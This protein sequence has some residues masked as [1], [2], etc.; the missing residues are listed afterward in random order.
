MVKFPTFFSSFLEGSLS[1]SL[2]SANKAL[3][4]RPTTSFQNIQSSSITHTPNPPTHPYFSFQKGAQGKTT[5]DKKEKPTQVINLAERKLQLEEENGPFQTRLN[6]QSTDEAIDFEVARTRLLEKR[7]K[8]QE[9]ILS[10]AKQNTKPSPFKDALRQKINAVANY[11]E[12][13]R[14]IKW[15][16]QDK[17]SWEAIHTYFDLQ[18]GMNFPSKYN[19]KFVHMLKSNPDQDDYDCYINPLLNVYFSDNEALSSHAF[20]ILK[21]I[22]PNPESWLIANWAPGKQNKILQLLEETYKGSFFT[23]S[24]EE[25]LIREIFKLQDT[26]KGQKNS[27][28]ILK[29]IFFAL[30]QRNET[31][32]KLINNQSEMLKVN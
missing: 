9:H 26:L 28:Q 19:R 7:K 1:T 3:Q 18:F 15:V 29:N 31:Y 21:R 5:P 4:Q 2:Y 14:F 20:H 10:L 8:E 11:L 30:S 24:N 32:K 16:N 23:N 25:T 22:K 6:I 27:Q 17:K 13:T 12:S